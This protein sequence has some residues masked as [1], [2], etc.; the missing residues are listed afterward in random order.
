MRFREQTRFVGFRAYSR[1]R[2]QTDSIE[3]GLFP[4]ETEPT[5]KP[6]L[7]VVGIPDFPGMVSG[8]PASVG[9]H[10]Y[11]SLIIGGGLVK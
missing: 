9:F 6:D 7:T 11:R 10:G 1:R 2:L 3:F 5:G 4:N 8:P